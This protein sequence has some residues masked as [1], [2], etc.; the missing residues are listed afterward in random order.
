MISCL[1]RNVFNNLLF[2]G[3]NETDLEL[4]DFN[5][6]VYCNYSPDDILIKEGDSGDFMLLIIS[7]TV[8][9]TKKI[10]NI[11]VKL[12]I[13]SPGEYVGEMALFDGELRSATVIAESEIEAYSINVEFFNYLITKLPKV[14]DNII[15]GITDTLR[16]NGVRI[17]SDKEKFI[18]EMTQIRKSLNQ[19]LELKR[20]INEQKSELELINRELERKNKELYKLTIF[21]DLTG[22]Y[23]K[24]HFNVLLDNELSK[25][26]RHSVVFG[27]LI[28]DIDDF[29]VFNDTFGHILGDCVLEEL[30]DVMQKLLRKED[31]IG[32]IGGEEFA[33]ILPHMDLNESMSVAYKIRDFLD[34]NMLIVDQ[35]PLKITVSIGVTDSSIDKPKTVQEIIYNGDIALYKAKNSGR[36]RVENFYSGMTMNSVL[37]DRCSF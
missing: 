36:N 28:L 27:L 29:K 10:N 1:N 22:S 11:D 18:S 6:F 13:R 8:V 3:I 15:K 17:I 21:D 4:L 9:V 7:G 19:T 14:K 25:S 2:E 31:I 23:S 20:Q 35:K 33:I 12:G 30:V 16:V 34:N 32:R 37:T 26:L 24:K 5:R